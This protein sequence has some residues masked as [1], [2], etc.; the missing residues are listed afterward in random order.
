MNIITKEQDLKDIQIFRYV[1]KGVE[2]IYGESD[3]NICMF[4]AST[5]VMFSFEGRGRRWFG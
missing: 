1:N 3:F 4:Y 2:R 5:F